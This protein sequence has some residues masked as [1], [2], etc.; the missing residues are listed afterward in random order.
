M[1]IKKD[2][3][4][5]LL[6]LRGTLLFCHCEALS[7]FVIA[8]HNVPKQSI[9]LLPGKYGGRELEGEGKSVAMY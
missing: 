4:T 7:S 8:R 1:T 5:P 9:L 3:M 6:S 2:T